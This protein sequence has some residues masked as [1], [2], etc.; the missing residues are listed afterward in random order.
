MRDHDF[1]AAVLASITASVI[2]L[3]VTDIPGD[4]L[5]DGGDDGADPTPRS[6]APYPSSSSTH[7][8]RCDDEKTQEVALIA[9]ALEVANVSA[10]QRVYRDRV[11]VNDGDIVMFQLWIQNREFERPLSNVRAGISI[12]DQ[13]AITVPVEARVCGSNTFLL[14][15]TASVSTN[16]FPIQL[17]FTQDSTSVRS[18][19][20][21]RYVTRGGSD[22]F[23]RSPRGES[24]GRLD[25]YSDR[26]LGF[27]SVA[28]RG[29]VQRTAR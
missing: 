9:G 26:K 7:A 10:G 4:L 24:L 2:V 14:R 13:P 11:M 28:V 3:V 8:I 19:I 22:A 23:F 18:Y 15:A 25:A 21:G 5:G 6:G 17:T 27:T 20:D 16:G 1:V 12:G 29:K